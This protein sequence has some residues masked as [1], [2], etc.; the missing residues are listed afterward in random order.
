MAQDKYTI[1]PALFIS[2]LY[3]FFE[4]YYSR[5]RKKVI[6]LTFSEGLISDILT[7]VR[8]YPDC[9]L[10]IGDVTHLL[11]QSYDGIYYSEGIFTITRPCIPEDF[12]PKYLYSGWRHFIKEALLDYMYEYNLENVVRYMSKNERAELEAELTLAK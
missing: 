11:P 8:N 3:N 2:E 9:K 6:C 4:E 10:N 7:Y 5:K 12:Y 1:H